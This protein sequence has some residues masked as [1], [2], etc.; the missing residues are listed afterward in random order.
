MTIKTG[1]EEIDALFAEADKLQDELNQIRKEAE[2]IL[3]PAGRGCP[4]NQ[5]VRVKQTA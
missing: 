2:D 1:W 3:Y 4:D 5:S